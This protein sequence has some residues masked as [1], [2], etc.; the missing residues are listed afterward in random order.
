LLGGGLGCGGLGCGG[1]GCGGLG[2]GLARRRMVAGLSVVRRAAAGRRLPWCFSFHR[3]ARN[4]TRPRPQELRCRIVQRTGPQQAFGD[5]F[6]QVGCLRD[7]HD[8]LAPREAATRGARR[9]E[10]CVAGSGVTAED[11]TEWI[12][13]AGWIL[14]TLRK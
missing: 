13:L 14:D 7:Q 4:L 12:G 5:A 10:T 6:D 2:C 11:A 9:V 1:L 8:R 3:L